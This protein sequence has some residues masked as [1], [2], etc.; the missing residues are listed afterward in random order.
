MGM[1]MALYSAS[2]LHC[3][4]ACIAFRFD[5]RDYIFRR[6]LGKLGVSSYLFE[7]RIHQAFGDGG[8]TV[9]VGSVMKSRFGYGQSSAVWIGRLGER[10][11][12]R[13]RSVVVLDDV[14]KPFACCNS[15]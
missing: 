7:V 8:W 15:T 4:S 14:T 3:L 9:A 13:V 12:R 6:W 10:M 1:V 2:R 11:R 5:G